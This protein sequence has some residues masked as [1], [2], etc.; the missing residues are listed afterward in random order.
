MSGRD[1]SRETSGLLQG[2]NL[3]RRSFGFSWASRR[4][5]ALRAGGVHLGHGEARE[6]FEKQIRWKR[7]HCSARKVN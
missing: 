7:E 5:W 4:R 1:G 3:R 2:N 6:G